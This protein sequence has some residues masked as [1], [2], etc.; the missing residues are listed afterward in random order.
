MA[1]SMA[2][3][4]LGA[5]QQL[6][7]EIQMSLHA[8]VER[9]AQQHDAAT[10]LSYLAVRAERISASARRLVSES[11]NA[12][13]EARVVSDVEAFA[14]DLG[15]TVALAK[16]DSAAGKA[17]AE[18]VLKHA[19]ILKSLEREM[20]DLDVAAIRARLRPLAVA[21]ANVPAMQQ[22]GQQR[23]AELLALAERAEQIS[24]MAASLGLA[25][26]E[27]RRAIIM[28]LSHSILSL[29]DDIAAAALAIGSVV[30]AQALEV[31]KAYTAMVR[32]QKGGDLV[33]K[34]NEVASTFGIEPRPAGRAMEWERPGRYR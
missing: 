2:P 22:A 4:P 6:L 32:E 19:G 29:A 3:E 28:K 14:A 18:A 16:Q 31:G 17:V 1:N 5:G 34:I 8:L 12:D 15:R 33:D 7:R 20:D 11:G 23:K 25:R 24:K 26:P 10:A 9:L 30:P 27:A 21:M 13:Q